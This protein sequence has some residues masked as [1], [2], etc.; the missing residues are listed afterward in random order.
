ME[1]NNLLKNLTNN[2]DKIKLIQKAILTGIGVASS[3]ETIKKAA[4]GIYKDVQKIIKELLS[5]LEK[6]GEIKTIETKKI[7]NELQKKSEIEKTKIYKKLQREGKTLISSAR[8]IILTPVN[9]LKD[10][11]ATLNI[12]N[13]KSKNTKRTSKKSLSKKKK[14]KKK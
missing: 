5:D 11:T 13:I 8:E 3:K 14:S 9:L 1:K 6:S 7:L 10:A 12:K 4:S 2:K